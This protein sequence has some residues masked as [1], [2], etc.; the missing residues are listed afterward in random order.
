MWPCARCGEHNSVELDACGQCGT[1][2]LAEVEGPIVVP[3]VGAVGRLD[4]SRQI[5]VMIAG[6][7]GVML[8]IVFVLA[9]VG[10]FL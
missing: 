6:G 10:S 7:A 5:A 3:V 9:V 8:L 1:P 2:F 4:K